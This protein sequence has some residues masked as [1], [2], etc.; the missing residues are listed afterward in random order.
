MQDDLKIAVERIAVLEGRVTAVECQASAT[1]AQVMSVS[2]DQKGMAEKTQAM[3]KE[4]DRGLSGR[5]R[6]ID[7]RAGR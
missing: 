1:S 4:Y 5:L 6:D 2:I 3:L 7:R